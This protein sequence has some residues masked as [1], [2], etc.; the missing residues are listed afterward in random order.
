MKVFYIIGCFLGLFAVAKSTPNCNYTTIGSDYVCFLKG[1]SDGGLIANEPEPGK[2]VKR[3]TTTDA[4]NDQIIKPVLSKFV[5]LESFQITMGTITKL[6]QNYFENQCK[7]L[8]QLHLIGGTISSFADGVFGPCPFLE[9]LVINDHKLGSISKGMIPNTIKM[10]SF[11][12][13]SIK[14]D[15]KESTIFD[16]NNNLPSLISLNLSSNAILSFSDTFH[17]PST[18]LEDLDFSSCQLSDI[19]TKLLETNKD[20]IKTLY[21]SGN[22][23]VN[24][25][26]TH[27]KSLTKLMKLK[28]GS[29]EIASIN[30]KAFE[31]NKELVLLNISDNKLQKLETDLLKETTKLESFAF[32]KNS[33]T[34]IPANFFE[35]TT[36]MKNLN[37]SNNKITKLSTAAF[38]KMTILEVLD[39]SGNQ[40]DAIERSFFDNL[41]TL[42][43]VKFGSNSC[44]KKDYN[45]FT[46]TDETTKTD[47]E[48][49]FRNFN[50]AQTIIIS[51]LLLVI[52]IVLKYF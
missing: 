14:V 49:C 20:T 19:P 15:P 40:I 29:N 28:L 46:I 5:D 11:A 13:N 17:L 34:E 16:A 32:D 42:K 36:A 9:D 8:K 37:G 25:S 45:N 47:F 43:T 48:T 7:K 44:I 21:L 27:L 10:L 35:K 1:S 33:I 4:A 39:L 30:S 50:G 52:A 23:F 24:V 51:N 2:T 3:V 22:K 26:D 38:A 31:L 12:I 6:E 41:K 18:K